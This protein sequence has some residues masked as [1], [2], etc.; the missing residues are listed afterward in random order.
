[1]RL[2]GRFWQNMHLRLHP[3]R[4]TVP[5]PPLPLMGGSSSRCTLT[6][7][8]LAAAPL[9]QRPRSPDVRSTPQLLGQRVQFL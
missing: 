4:N 2:R 9:P 3:D 6:L 8:T 1:M 7:A 5:E